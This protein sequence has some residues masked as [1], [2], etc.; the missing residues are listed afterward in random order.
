[1][2]YATLLCE[3]RSCDRAGPT[4]AALAVGNGGGEG[5]ARGEEVTRVGV[6][7]YTYI[8]LYSGAP[9][10]C[11]CL[12]P[13]TPAGSHVARVSEDVWPLVFSLFSPFLSG[14]LLLDMDMRAVSYTGT[15]RVRARGDA[16]TLFFVLREVFVNGTPFVRPHCTSRARSIHLEQQMLIPFGNP[17][18]LDMSSSRSLWRTRSQS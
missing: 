7:I 9:L 1:M 12:Q 11:T 8:V 18:I 4:A 16:K 2:R 14:F 10:R 6:A 5:G 17:H 13:K 15:R 3:C